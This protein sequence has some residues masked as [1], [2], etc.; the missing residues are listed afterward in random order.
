MQNNI[1][2]FWKNIAVRLVLG[3]LLFLMV[4][5]LVFDSMTPVLV[6]AFS[7]FGVGVVGVLL[8]TVCCLISFIVNKVK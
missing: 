7:I 4:G 2:P 6:L 1:T 8:F 3:L 5:S